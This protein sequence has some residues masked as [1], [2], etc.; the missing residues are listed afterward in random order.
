MKQ[1][2]KWKKNQTKKKKTRAKSANWIKSACVR[3]PFFICVL[4]N[5]CARADDLIKK[6]KVV[7]QL[8]RKA[9]SVSFLPLSLSFPR[10]SLSLCVCVCL[11][12]TSTIWSQLES[13]A[14]THL[15]SRNQS[16]SRDSSSRRELFCTYRPGLR[17]FWIFLDPRRPTNPANWAAAGRQGVQRRQH[18]KSGR[19]IA[20]RQCRFV[21]SGRYK[22]GLMVGQRFGFKRHFERSAFWRFCNLSTQ[23]YRTIYLS[24]VFDF[25]FN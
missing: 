11:H 8:H 16:E 20:N 2:W 15:V 17:G 23:L 24:L 4:V 7:C 18:T 10:P 14:N 25:S 22:Y 5:G 12:G 9:L 6:H 13:C 19:W 1:R 21:E 3:C